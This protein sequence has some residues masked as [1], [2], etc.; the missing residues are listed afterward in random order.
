MIT[1]FFKKKQEEGEG[2]QVWIVDTV[3][4]GP[5]GSTNAKCWRWGGQRQAIAWSLQWSQA[6]EFCLPLPSPHLPN[7]RSYPASLSLH[8]PTLS[9]PIPHFFIICMDESI[10]YRKKNKILEKFTTTF[11]H[12]MF[13]KLSK[14]KIFM[15]DMY[16]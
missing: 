6:S 3:E 1:I 7:T 12:K 10:S 13:M 16:W 5:C 2:N 4:R 14:K 8:T 15:K 9:I 11:L